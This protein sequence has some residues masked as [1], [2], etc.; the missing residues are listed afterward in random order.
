MC[1]ITKG[2]PGPYYGCYIIY[3]KHKVTI[4]LKI[5]NKTHVA[6]RVSSKGLWTY[7][8]LFFPFLILGTGTQT[9]GLVTELIIIH[10]HLLNDY[11]VLY[12]LF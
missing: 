12:T 9:S 7:S 11:D 4:F 2:Y 8:D 5:K 10:F 6:P 1:L 3:G